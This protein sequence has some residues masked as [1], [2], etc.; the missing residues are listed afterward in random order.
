ML[1][2][3][4]FNCAAIVTGSAAAWQIVA[5]SWCRLR[6]PVGV[7]AVFQV[8]VDRVVKVIAVCRGL[9]LLFACVAEGTRY[10]RLV[11][12]LQRTFTS[13]GQL[14]ALLDSGRFHR[15][16]GGVESWETERVAR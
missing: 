10:R 5:D 15:L 8:E 6:S 11:I 13:R 7:R 9:V 4:D 12:S 14:T 2:A 1:P 16:F 3:A